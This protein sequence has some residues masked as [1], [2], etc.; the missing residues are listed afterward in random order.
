[1]GKLVPIELTEDGRIPVAQDCPQLLGVRYVL[2]SHPEM[3]ASALHD[4]NEDSEHEYALVKAASTA[5][6]K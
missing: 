4:E 1:M 6:T 3:Y 2:N 5:G